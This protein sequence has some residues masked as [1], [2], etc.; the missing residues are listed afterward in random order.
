MSETKPDSL[1]ARLPIE[2]QLFAEPQ[3]PEAAQ[4]IEEPPKTRG[5]KFY[6]IFQF[7]SGKIFII[8]VTAALA[9]TADQKYAPEKIAGVPNYLK[10]FQGWF[11][12]QVFHNPIY[13]VAEKGDFAKLV[14]GGL[15]STM[16]L[17]HGG[18]FF[19]PFIRWLENDREKISNA[20][21]KQFGTPEEVEITHERL[22]D[23]P[24]QNWMDVA[25]GRAMA[26]GT[27]FG[28]M[29]TAYTV[30]GKE[31]KSGRYWLDIYEDAF[32]RKF[33]GLTAAGKEIA[34]TPVAKALTEA[35]QANNHYRFGKVLALDLYAT[36]A[37]IVIWNMFSRKSAKSRTLH[38]D[39]VAEGPKPEEFTI[40]ALEKNPKPYAQRE[41]KG[42]R[43]QIQKAH[44]F[45]EAVQQPSLD[46]SP[47]MGI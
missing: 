1:T 34:A 30:A 21:N 11:H 13:P 33:A 35:Q 42:S 37:G 19:A 47:G 6:D 7:F 36:S 18:N 12:K 45:T 17:S 5:E 14:G 4:K 31:K 39:I 9:F 26:W 2:P 22:K 27:V 23:I 16:I 10:K 29:V 44:S 8:A 24:K 28:A 46:A 40:T 20:Y 25:K 32:A 3:T 43:A 15:V 38:D 41:S